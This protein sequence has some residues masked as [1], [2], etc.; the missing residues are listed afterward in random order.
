MKTIYTLAALFALSGAAMAD[1]CSTNW[2]NG[3]CGVPKSDASHTS[4][5]PPPKKPCHEKTV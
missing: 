1:S 2:V 3:A 5:A 4:E